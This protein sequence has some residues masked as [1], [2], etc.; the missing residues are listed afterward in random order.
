VS[1]TG[2]KLNL[3]VFFFLNDYFDCF[4]NTGRLVDAGI[5]E[6]LE[7]TDFDFFETREMLSRERFPSVDDFWEG[8]NGSGPF[9]EMYDWVSSIFIFTIAESI[10]SLFGTTIF[11]ISFPVVYI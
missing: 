11:V 4:L 9:L 10:C 5:L 8:L 3:S 7:Y 1:G 6:F 2:S